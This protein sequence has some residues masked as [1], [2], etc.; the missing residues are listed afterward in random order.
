METNQLMTMFIDTYSK[1]LKDL[2]LVL[3]SSMATYQVSFEQY[4]ILRDIANERV[5][6]LT[7]IVRL[8]GVTKPAIARQ[9]RTLRDL[10]YVTQKTAT[11][12][13]RQHV[14]NLTAAGRQVEH[15]IT[16]D[17]NQLFDQF[18]AAVG[19]D[20]VTELRDLLDLVDTNYLTKIKRD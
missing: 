7:D 2:N 13:R 10:D 19:I 9:L 17:V 3:Q 1:T 11:H 4:Q 18:V 5:T 14:L 15:D 16:D 6:N 20:K 8:R 12:D